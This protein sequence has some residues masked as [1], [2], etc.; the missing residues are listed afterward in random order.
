MIKI[1]K[2]IKM[3][4][5][6][7]L[8]FRFSTQYDHEKIIEHLKIADLPFSDIDFTKIEFILAEKDS[9]LIGTIAIEKYGKD[10]LLRS[11]AVL[12]EYSG[13]RIGSTLFQFLLS[14]AKISNIETL[15]LLTSTAVKYFE[16]KGF[17]V[18]SRNDAPHSI[19]ATSE[20][21]S[22]CPSSSIYMC[23]KGLGKISLV[24]TSWL[25]P[26]RKDKET[27]SKYWSISGEK[28]MFTNFCMEPFKTFESHSHECEQI[29]YVLEGKLYFE[30]GNE[31][32]EMQNGDSI[33]IPSNIPHKV[34]TQEQMAI[35]VDSWCPINEKL[36]EN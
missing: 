28:M 16:R 22:I 6:P 34:W 27:G 18:A 9:A 1:F 19:K 14:Y 23:F 8:S 26:F 2:L 31:T 15:H 24:Y 36:I 3:T 17:F 25:H 12:K 32:Y 7:G 29:T 13:L 21:S 33:V 4:H 30:I 20:F 11:F 10:G 35:A 5:I